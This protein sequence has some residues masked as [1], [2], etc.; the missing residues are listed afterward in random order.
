MGLGLKIRYS[1]RRHCQ[2]G[3]HLPRA[4]MHP[5]GPNRGSES[6]RTLELP[7]RKGTSLYSTSKTAAELKL[8]ASKSN[9]C[10]G[11]QQ[12][13]AC[14]CPS[15]S[16]EFGRRHG[17]DPYLLIAK[18]SQSRVREIRASSAKS[19]IE[20]YSTLLARLKAIGRENSAE[21]R[22]AKTQQESM[23]NDIRKNTQTPAG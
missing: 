9:S 11:P 10:A 17:K 7:P 8:S 4:R 12:Q 20:S 18:L 14:R 23:M 21:Y 1:R 22:A 2:V 13:L 5:S 3:L 16:A 6:R 15:Y 19:R